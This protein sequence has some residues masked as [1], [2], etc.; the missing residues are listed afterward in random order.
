[1]DALTIRNYSFQ[2]HGSR[3]V[4]GQW[5]TF[6]VFLFLK[7]S[8]C[9][10]QLHLTAMLV[11]QDSFF[12]PNMC[13]LHFTPSCHACL[14][15]WP[16]GTGGIII[17]VTF[18]EQHILLNCIW[19]PQVSARWKQQCF[20][21]AGAAHEQTDP[22]KKLPSTEQKSSL[23][24][25]LASRGSLSVQCEMYFATPIANRGVC[26]C[27]LCECCNPWEVNLFGTHC[28]SRVLGHQHQSPSGTTTC[29][30]RLNS[31]VA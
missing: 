7:V 28:S 18:A 10:F 19:P 24:S 12:L 5:R 20:F 27:C 11:E 2:L 9:W 1:M 23:S 4:Q 15:A 25:S 29:G 21:L 31:P 22:V 16:Q 17:P 6:D 30:Q 13:L 3:I 26:G 14:S 8:L